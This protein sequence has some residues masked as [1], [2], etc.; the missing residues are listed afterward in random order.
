MDPGRSIELVLAEPQYRDDDPLE[1]VSVT[2]ST[3]KNRYGKILQLAQAV[4][5]A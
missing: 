5:V 1:P 3:Q 4:M 2:I